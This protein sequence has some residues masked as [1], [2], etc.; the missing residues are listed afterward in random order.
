MALWKE[1]GSVGESAAAA[2]PHAPAYLSPKS[3]KYSFEIPGQDAE[4]FHSL[5]AQPVR[6]VEV[7]LAEEPVSSASTLEETIAEEAR[8]VEI[9]RQR[10]RARATEDP[11]ARTFGWVALVGSALRR[12]RDARELTQTVLSEKTSI[13]QG[14]LSSVETGKLVRGPTMD[15]LYRYAAAL[16]CDCEIVLR[17]RKSGAVV[18]SMQSSEITDPEVSEDI[19]SSADLF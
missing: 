17:D 10:L 4:Y 3:G 8:N 12:A 7:P 13:T 1:S 14:Y 16:N 18:T 19:V 2:S 11:D 15:V 9:L 6:E 5:E